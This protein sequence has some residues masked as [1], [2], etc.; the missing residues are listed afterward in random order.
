MKIILTE[1]EIRLVI[2]CILNVRD[3]NDAGGSDEQNAEAAELDVIL[4]KISDQ[5]GEDVSP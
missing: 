2:G 1:R 3:Q 4:T 5:T